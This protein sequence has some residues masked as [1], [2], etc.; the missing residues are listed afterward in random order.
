MAA[1]ERRGKNQFSDNGFQEWGGYMEAKKLKLEEQ[2]LKLSKNENTAQCKKQKG[3]FDGVAI[4]VNG[5]TG[6]NLRD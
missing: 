1:K 2:Y 5:Y 4:Y 3:I 6:N